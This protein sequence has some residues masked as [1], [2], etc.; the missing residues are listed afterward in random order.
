MNGEKVLRLVQEAEGIESRLLTLRQLVRRNGLS[1]EDPEG[2]RKSRLEIYQLE[3][4]LNEI[5]SDP[6]FREAER[7]AGMSR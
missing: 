5:N 1:R 6:D 3:A 2:T 4:R 7:L